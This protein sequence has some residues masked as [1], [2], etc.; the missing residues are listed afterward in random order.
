MSSLLLQP[1]ITGLMLSINYVLV[2]LG[3]VL[4]F[5]IVNIFQFSHGTIYMVGG[6]VTYVI[7]G[8][9]GLNYFLSLILAIVFVGLL[10]VLMEI[11]LLRYSK[12]PD[13]DIV[14]TLGI[15]LILQQAAQLIFGVNPHKVPSVVEGNLAL[16]GASISY[17]RTLAIGLGVV[18]LLA[19]FLYMRKARDGQ[20]MIASAQNRVGAALVGINIGKMRILAMFIGSGLAGA[21]GAIIAPIFFVDPYMWVTPLNKALSVMAVGGLGSIPGAVG[22]G[23]IIGMIDSFASRLVSI[24]VATI[25]N[26]L[27][28]VLILIFRPTGLAGRKTYIES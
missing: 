5:G 2:A 8:E 20:A 19:L 9:L 21:A 26:F 24:P 22:A 25:T 4:I 18:V 7:F 3:L 16:F 15:I 28:V 17:E 6:F 14:I 12:S 11:G 10:G 23:F 27:F 13:V 1:F